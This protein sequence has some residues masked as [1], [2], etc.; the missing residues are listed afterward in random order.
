MRFKNELDI[1]VY[2]IAMIVGIA[3]ISVDELK[4]N[5]GKDSTEPI[6]QGKNHELTNENFA[7]DL[8][9]K[10]I[11]YNNNPILKWNLSNA[12]ID[13]DKNNNISLIKTS[14]QRRRIDGVRLF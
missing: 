2:K 8:E 3:F 5:F 7:A 6:I 4:Q 12:A 13:V 11:N 9:A 14:N 1:Y 10:R